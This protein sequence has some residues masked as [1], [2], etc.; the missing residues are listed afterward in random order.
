MAA[1]P[2]EITPQGHIT[3]SIA[4]AS[5]SRPAAAMI[6][7]K[8]GPMSVPQRGRAPW[9]GQRGRARDRQR[10]TQNPVDSLKSYAHGRVGSCVTGRASATSTG[11]FTRISLRPKDAECLLAHSPLPSRRAPAARP[12]R[13]GRTAARREPGRLSERALKGAVR[14]DPPVDLLRCQRVATAK[15]NT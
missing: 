13:Y 15:L 2:L 14:T 11:H 1:A 6:S 4:V 12:L 8:A 7:G 3:Q 9:P 10:T 5:G